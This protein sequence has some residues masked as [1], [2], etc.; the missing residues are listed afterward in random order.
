MKA[1]YLDESGHLQYME[2]GC[3]GIGISRIVAAA[4]EQNHDQHGIIFPAAM[5]PFQL[6][7]IPIGL[8]KNTQVKDMTNKLYQQFLDAQIE[9]FLDDRDER[10]GVMFADMELIGIPHRIVIGERGLKQSIVEYQERKEQISQT[11][12]INEIFSFI[13]NKL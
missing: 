13:M 5:A 6:A 3:Y 7:I 12:P 8:Q 10:P 2:M 4:I 11:I 1:G 9:V